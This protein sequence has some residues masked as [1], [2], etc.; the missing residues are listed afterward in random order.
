ML[1]SFCEMLLSITVFIL[2]LII[3]LKG[4]NPNKLRIDSL[5]TGFL[6]GFFT[7]FFLMGIMSSFSNEL[8]KLNNIYNILLLIFVLFLMVLFFIMPWLI[9]NRV[10]KNSIAKGIIEQYN[11]NNK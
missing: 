2:N 6:S 3:I 4:I 9:T 7:F 8:D 10:F 11:L 1:F 5:L